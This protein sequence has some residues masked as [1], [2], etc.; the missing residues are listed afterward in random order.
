M[1]VLLRL[2][3]DKSK[4]SVARGLHQ[5]SAAGMGLA[6]APIFLRSGTRRSRASSPP[7]N[8]A[9]S[10]SSNHGTVVSLIRTGNLSSTLQTE[11]SHESIHAAIPESVI[12]EIYRLDPE[13][14]VQAAPNHTL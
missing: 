11:E 5:V 2:R 10:C 12:R 8:P 13:V 14:A 3:G 7:A 4:H 9:R 6:P 1:L